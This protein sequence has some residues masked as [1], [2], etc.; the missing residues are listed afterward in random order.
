LSQV[1][2]D[3]DAERRVAVHDGDAELNL[4]DLLVKVPRHALTGSG[5][6][7]NHETEE[8]PQ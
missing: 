7:A 2:R 8:L 1:P 6:L 4:R 3:K 5:S